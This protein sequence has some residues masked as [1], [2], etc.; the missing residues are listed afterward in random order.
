M[1]DE[2]IEEMIKD[3]YA[4]KLLA[5]KEAKQKTKQAAEQG[6]KQGMKQGVEQGVKQ[7]LVSVVQA[8]FASLLPLAEERCTRLKT[9]A[10]LQQLLIQIVQSQ[11]EDEARR[12]LLAGD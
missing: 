2:I 1:I 11:D 9:S 3:S 5:Q 7:A 8:R 10:Q 12:F 6:M 4:C